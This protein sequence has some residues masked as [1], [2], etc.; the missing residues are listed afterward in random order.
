MPVP[1]WS[2]AVPTMWMQ[3]INHR[4]SSEKLTT[5]VHEETASA[6]GSASGVHVLPGGNLRLIRIGAAHLPHAEAVRL[7]DFFEG[8]VILPTYSMSECMPITSPPANYGLQRPGSVGQPVGDLVVTIR[9]AD[10]S[11]PAA[12]VG[13]EI[14]L[15]G[16]SQLFSGYLEQDLSSTISREP[17]AFCTGDMGHVEDGWLYITGRQKEV[18]NRGGEL[19]SPLEVEVRWLC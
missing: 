8:C 18:I 3:L 15:A 1:S 13:G 4:L 12:G 11:V 6:A 19:I 17:L 9:A 10:G 16:G 14:C 5:G 2:Y 7:A